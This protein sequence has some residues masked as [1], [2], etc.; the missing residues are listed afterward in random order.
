MNGPQVLGFFCCL[1]FI[2]FLF[3]GFEVAVFR[4]SCALCRVPQ[5]GLARTCGLVFLLLIVP[6][7]VDGIFSG[8]LIEVY[9]AS[10]YPLWE[11]GVVQFFLALP[12]HMAICSA[13]HAKTVGIRVG[14][15]LS[16]WLVEKLLKLALVVA[17]VGIITVLI[18]A[19]PG[20]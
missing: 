13:I 17:V 12:A 19:G 3:L 18:L 16:V 15:G 5:P 1:G 4:I 20:K 14:Q 11:A 9:K 7:I 10:E 2:L 6:A 8:V